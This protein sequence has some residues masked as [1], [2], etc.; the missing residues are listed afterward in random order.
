M[1]SAVSGFTDETVNRACEELE[2]AQIGQFDK[3][4]SLNTLTELCR[5]IASSRRKTRF[6]GRCREGYIRRSDGQI[7]VCECC[8][9]EC[10]NSGMTTV[11]R[12]VPKLYG[13]T[14]IRFAEKCR[15]Q[16]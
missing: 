12:K 16:A 13:D 8:C 10:M 1:A 11:E 4:V 9:P 7:V 15:C 2:M 3:N 14:P 5:K 6:C